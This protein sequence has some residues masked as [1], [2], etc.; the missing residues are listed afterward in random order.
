MIK[1]EKTK[2]S[3]LYVFRVT[4]E[5]KSWIEEEVQAAYD[6]INDKRDDDERVVSKSQIL[7]EALTLGFHGLKKSKIN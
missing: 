5:E 3:V 4:D 1:R 2:K 7:I 6:R